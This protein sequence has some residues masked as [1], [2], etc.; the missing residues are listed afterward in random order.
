MVKS[1]GFDYLIQLLLLCTAVFSLLRNLWRLWIRARRA[2]HEKLSL[3]TGIPKNDQGLQKV[4]DEIGNSIALIEKLRTL[5]G[6]LS[7][8]SENIG[9]IQ[10][11][12]S[13]ISRLGHPSRLEEFRQI[14]SDV[15]KYLQEVFEPE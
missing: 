8:V 5:Q 14:T 6:H 4:P 7:G 3:I 2:V 10:E 1:V 11:F 9:F 12:N 13:R 15:D